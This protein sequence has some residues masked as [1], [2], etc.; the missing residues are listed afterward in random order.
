[1]RLFPE[2]FQIFILK[3]LAEFGGILSLITGGFI[4]I[5]IIS[6]SSFDPT[7]NNLS[8]QD[9]TNLGGSL[10][11]N[12]SDILLQLFGYSS[13]I[14]ALILAAWSFKLIK[15]KKLSFFAINLF[16]IPFFLVSISTTFEITQLI[17]VNG[18]LSR[19]IIGFL[20]TLE[21]ISETSLF[22]SILVLSIILSIIFLYF[23]MGLNLNEWKYIFSFIANI[24]IKIFIFLY[25]FLKT[26]ILKKSYKTVKADQSE[27]SFF[28]PK[29]EPK[30]D[31][32]NLR[33]TP[34]QEYNKSSNDTPFIKQS[35]INLENSNS[36]NFPSINL[37]TQPNSESTEQYTK[38]ELEQNAIKL[39]DVLSDFKIDGEIINVAPGP[40]V[41]MYELQPAPGIKASK[42]IALS[43]DIAR[44]MS[45][46]S[47]RVAII[48]GKNVVGIEIPNKYKDSV[49]LS[50]LFSHTNFASSNKNLLLALGKDINGNAIFTNLEDMP[51]LLIAG[52]TGSGKSVGINVMIASILYRLSPEDCKFILIDPKMLELSVYEGI[53]HLI[54]PVVTDPKQ[55]IN[56]LKWVVKEMEGRYQK[57]SLLGVRNIE[58]YNLRIKESLKKSE[59]IF[60][61]IPAGINPDTGQPQT[62]KIEIELKKMPFIIVVVDEMADL[63][64]VAGKE[65]EHAIQRLSQMARAAGIH[66][67]MATQRPSVDVITGTIKANFPTRISFQVSS[68]FDSRT[69]LGDEGAERLLGKGDMLMMNAGGRTTRIHGPFISDKEIEDIV[70]SLRQQGLPEFDEDVIREEANNES[71]LSSV[72]ESDKDELFKDSLQIIAREGKASTSLLQRKLQI[73]YNRAARIMDQLEEQ[74]YISAA[75]HV[76]KRE[77]NYDK[78][79]T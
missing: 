16:L 51:H 68:K 75:N 19:E 39:K 47:A 46:M 13:T 36:Y 23:C 11:A 65:I 17:S 21:F 5:S 72:N 57:M 67:I 78:I 61:S 26:T 27:K 64:M 8:S 6:H 35:E 59:Q 30:I 10:G 25:T 69:I 49:Y 54:T 31:F 32:E 60:R 45:A 44:N 33:S 3:R 9:V 77:I 62:K 73:G 38:E 56:A 63:M 1:M 42:I 48:P 4:L 71:S 28:E 15:D 14:I 58:N 22:Y 7:I 79:N 37:L 74:G 18:F 20:Q 66:L 12:L 34:V 50:E 2:A 76:G 24:F 70:S 43:D 55:A 52:T 40:I 41:T 29:I 53:P